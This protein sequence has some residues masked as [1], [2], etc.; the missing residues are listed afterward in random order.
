M[1]TKRM[2]AIAVND[3]QDRIDASIKRLL[4]DGI[5]PLPRHHQYADMLQR[6]QLETIADWLERIQCEDAPKPSR[7][8]KSKAVDNGTDNSTD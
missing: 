3:A 8:R 2:N 5:T 4:G 7:R 1:A 6:V